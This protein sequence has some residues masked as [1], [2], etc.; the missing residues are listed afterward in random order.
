MT[1]YPIWPTNQTPAIGLVWLRPYPGPWR[2]KE[3]SNV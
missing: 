1:A 2:P 3:S